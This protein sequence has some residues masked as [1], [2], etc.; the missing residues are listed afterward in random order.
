MAEPRRER[1]EALRNGKKLSRTALAAQVGISY[2]H[3]WGIERGRHDA[4]PD[5]LC[6][7]AL[8]LDADID[9]VMVR[10][11]GED[12]TA[13]KPSAEPRVPPSR[14]EPVRPVPPPGE[15]RGPR[16]TEAQAS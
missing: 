10:R 16:R 5:I 1:I 3:L 9:D 8:A 2:K 7:I 4:N 11:R 15:P 6:R 12:E 13:P 14:P